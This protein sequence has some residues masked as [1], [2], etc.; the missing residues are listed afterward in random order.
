MTVTEA[1]QRSFSADYTVSRTLEPLSPYFD[2]PRVT[3]IRINRPGEV[4]CHLHG[5]KEIHQ[6]ED[7]DWAYLNRLRSTLISSNRLDNEP[8][9]NV[10]LPN[11][12]RGIICMPPAV[13]EGTIQIAFRKHS[14][15]VK[16]LDEL[17]AEGAFT[18]WT[19]VSFN[20]PTPEQVE[21][22]M[23]RRDFQRLDAG[24]AELLRLLREGDLT[25]FFREAVR[26]K[27]N[28]VIAGKTGSGKTTFTRSLILEVPKSERIITIE[29]VHELTLREDQSEVGHLLYGS[30]PGR[31]SVSECL[32]AC[33]RLS[34]DRIMLAELRDSAALEYL[35]GLNNGHP[36]SIT[37][38]HAGGALMTFNRI[39]TLIRKSEAGRLLDLADI[40]RELHTT[41]DV[42]VFMHDRQIKEVFY[43]PMF[44]KSKLG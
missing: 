23:Q 42:T 30:V 27:R 22:E 7:I 10:L 12:A 31:M 11:G 8:V 25:G 38:T 20:R 15:V 34:P 5:G 36:G 6:R 40:M 13:L 2:D 44:K 43:D 18:D 24:E 28:I 41:I 21:T 14:D 3:E 19:D 33:M 17:A 16:S 32:A 1:P 39:A 35:E 9:S 37:T 4:V 29:D 26:L